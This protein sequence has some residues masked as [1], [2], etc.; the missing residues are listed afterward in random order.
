MKKNNEQAS[1]ME[2]KGC[3]HSCKLS[4]VIF[5]SRWTGSNGIGR[6]SKEIAERLNFTKLY[7]DKK[8]P[9]GF[10]STFRLGLWTTSNTGGYI[11]S[12]SYIPPTP[13]K[14]PFTF[15]IHDLNHI[16][17]PHNS[18]LLKRIYYRLIILPAVHRSH[19]VLTVSEFSKNR[20]VDWSGCRPDKVKVVGNGVSSAFNQSA[21]PIK[22][23]YKYI[24][25]CSNRKGHKNEIRLLQAFKASNLHNAIKLV[26]TGASDRKTTKTIQELELGNAVIYTGKISEVELAS[27]YRGAIATIFP[28][29]YEGFG[30][31][32]IESM[33]CG[34]P[35]VASNT[36]SLPEVGGN[37]GYYVDPLSIQSISAGI[38]HVVENEN[39]RNEMRQKGLVRT[40]LFTWD[41]TA[42]LVRDAI[43]ELMKSK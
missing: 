38:K 40:N 18:S 28:S 32:I 25:C 4:E 27:W 6:F 41:R 34:T 21:I 15:T 11:F 14:L 1:K 31:P 30:L 9:A 36:T 13:S 35:V 17:V 7:A 37:A 3:D 19:S 16:D 43:E 2:S 42:N 20:I 12:P 29:L 26:F 24:F 23:G 5:D 8:N 10:L 39:L 33:A 22:P